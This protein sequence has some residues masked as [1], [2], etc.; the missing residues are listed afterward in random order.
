MS[1]RTMSRKRRE[2]RADRRIGRLGSR[3]VL[4]D[5]EDDDDDDDEDDDDDDM[6][7]SRRRRS[8]RSRR[9][10]DS[11]RG[12]VRRGRSRIDDNEAEIAKIKS[13][14]EEIAKAVESMID[15][16]DALTKG[17]AKSKAAIGQD[18]GTASFG[19]SGD[20]NAL[21]QDLFEKS[22][23]DGGVNLEDN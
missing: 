15:K 9:E 20:D 18:G 10:S 21:M 19:Q 23:M 12:P 6:E 3:S 1:F 22:V 14:V 7:K 4:R 16:V 17:T 13:N 5:D 11:L 8:S 2:G